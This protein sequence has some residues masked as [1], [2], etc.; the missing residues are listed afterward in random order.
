MCL[1][2]HLDRK[3]SEQIPKP[4]ELIHDWKFYYESMRGSLEIKIIQNSS[5]LVKICPCAHTH[6]FCHAYINATDLRE[7]RKLGDL[8]ALD[9][10]F[11]LALVQ[12]SYQV[13]LVSVLPALFQSIEHYTT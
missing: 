5:I 4:L 13:S 3:H 9:I 10:I 7:R 1:L 6:T 11:Y 8:K 12:L 2:C